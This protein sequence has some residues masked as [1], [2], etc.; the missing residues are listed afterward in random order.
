M[1]SEGEGLGSSPAAALWL[2]GVGAAA[3]ARY[4]GA[5]DEDEGAEEDVDDLG[6]GDVREAIWAVG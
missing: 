4:G 1:I 3:S 2:V 5:D 6:H